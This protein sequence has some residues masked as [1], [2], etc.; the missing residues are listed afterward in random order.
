MP[1][2]ERETLR[3][4]SERLGKHW[5]GSVW[6]TLQMR[7][8]LYLA[9]V[10]SPMGRKSEH[11]ATACHSARVLPSAAGIIPLAPLQPGASLSPSRAPST[12][13]AAMIF[14]SSV[15]VSLPV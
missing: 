7:A 15:Y 9:N 12:L 13:I 10:R 5:D 1:E 14:A 11:A 8:Y 6:E 4:P 3:M 2:H